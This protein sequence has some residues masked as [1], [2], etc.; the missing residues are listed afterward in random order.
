MDT[1]KAQE[2]YERNKARAKKYY[3]DN[4]EKLLARAKQYQKEHYEQQKANMRKY[5]NTHKDKIVEYNK[6]Y[7]KKKYNNNETIREK[8]LLKTYHSMFFNGKLESFK[9]FVGLNLI[10]YKEY[11]TSILPEG[12]EL[13]NYKKKW[14]IGRIDNNIDVNDK[15]NIKKFFNYKNIKINIRR[16]KLI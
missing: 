5:V 14:T 7:K 15:A 16:K 12:C 8:Q 6:Q 1:K 13:G 3:Q 11:I 10:Q 4:K 9:E 2:Y